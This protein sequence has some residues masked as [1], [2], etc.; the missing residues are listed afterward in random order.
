[1]RYD[2]I[3]FDLSGTLVNYRGPVVGWEAMERLGFTAVHTLLHS[4]GH[5]DQM[6]AADHFHS[7][8]FAQLR[9]AWKATLAGERNLHLADLLR[10]ALAAQG[11]HPSET[12]IVE[13]VRHY[14]RAISAGAFP[15]LG[16][17]ELLATLRGE[18][19]RVGLISNTMWPGEHHHED[20]E[21][22]G[23]ASLI[24]VEIY[25]ADRNAWKPSPRV[26]NLALDALDV[27]PERT[28][29]VGDNPV[30]DII[31]ARNSGL[32][33]VWIT[34]GEYPIEAGGAADA[35]IRELPDLVQVLHRLEG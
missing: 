1:M 15:R 20:L 28:L 11:V 31:G 24:E 22:F 14:T 18:G 35:I 34:T 12:T 4:N 10:E 17:A 13:A 6:P 7:A 2:A 33:A 32:D 26:F 9:R 19:R 3:L 25:S 29:F 5:R 27:T 16:A 8:A 23:L 30:D 21:R